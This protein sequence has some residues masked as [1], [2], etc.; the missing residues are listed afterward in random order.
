MV[1]HCAADRCARHRQASGHEHVRPAA[2]SHLSRLDQDGRRCRAVVLY[3]ISNVGM[4]FGFTALLSR[5]VPNGLLANPVGPEVAKRAVRRFG[6]GTI[7]Y[8]L[9]TA[10]GLFWPPLILIAIAVLA[11]YYMAEQ[12]QILPNAD[13]AEAGP[14]EAEPAHCRVPSERTKGEGHADHRHPEAR[15]GVTCLWLNPIHPS[16]NRHAGYDVSDYYAV[17]QRLRTLVSFSSMP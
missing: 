1:V 4:A 12:T 2:V 8:Q 10:A 6:L 9:A 5:I 17:D 16:A 13:G 7:A 3:G 15:L 14:K 11:V